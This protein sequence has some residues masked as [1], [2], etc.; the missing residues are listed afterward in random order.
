M[1]RMISEGRKEDELKAYAIRSHG[2]TTL[3][4]EAVKM[5]LAGITTFEEMERLIYTIDMDYF[6]ED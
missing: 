6:G 1:K 5:V 4:E 2:M 3:K